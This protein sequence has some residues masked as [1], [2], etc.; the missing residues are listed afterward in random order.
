MDQKSPIVGGLTP[1]GSDSLGK[2]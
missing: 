2:L 1:V